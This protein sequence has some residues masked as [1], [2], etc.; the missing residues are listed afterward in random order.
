MPVRADGTRCEGE[1]FEVQARQAMGNLLEILSAAGGRPQDLVKVTAY[2]KGIEH[3]PAFNG[4]YAA[5]MGEARPA[6]AI[7]PVPALHHNLLVEVEGCAVV[8]RAQA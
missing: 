3:W 8:P 2:I 5:M 1:P 6:R 4:V 7:V